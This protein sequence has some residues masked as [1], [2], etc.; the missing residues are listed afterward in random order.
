[1]K[2]RQFLEVMTS[3]KQIRNQWV[4]DSH[5]EIVEAQCPLPK[6]LPKFIRYLDRSAQWSI[7]NFYAMKNG[8]TIAQAVLHNLA[9]AVCDG[10]F[11]SGKGAAAWVIEGESSVDRIKGW[12]ITVGKYDAHSAYRSEFAGLF[13]T[14]TM[15]NAI[16]QLHHINSGTI[17]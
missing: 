14:V 17:T 13:G 11:K 8:N 10:F 16:C 2:E 9:I 12:N 4:C 5:G 7:K 1:M 6:M 3:M 15:V